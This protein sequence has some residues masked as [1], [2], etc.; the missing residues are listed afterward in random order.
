MGCSGF[1]AAMADLDS[2]VKVFKKQHFGYYINVE[3]VTDFEGHLAL[4]AS[5][6]YFTKKSD[7]P[8]LHY[9]PLPFLEDPFGVIHKRVQAQ[10]MVEP[11]QV[12]RSTDNDVMFLRREPFEDAKGGW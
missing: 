8:D 7:A 9:R 3:P 11:Q 1:E 10:N 2:I 4:T 6:R 12:V 5:S